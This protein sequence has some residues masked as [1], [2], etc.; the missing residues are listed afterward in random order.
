MHKETLGSDFYRSTNPIYR[1]D[2]L[3]QIFNVQTTP[4]SLLRYDELEKEPGGY[5]GIWAK[6]L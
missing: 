6:V 2:N 4:T 1:A 5:L 3:V